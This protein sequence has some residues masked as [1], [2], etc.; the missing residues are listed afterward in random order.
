M[1]IGLTQRIFYHKQRAYDS[2]E[3][4]WYSF[5]KGHTLFPIAND[6]EQDFK[7]L[8]HSLD[9]LIITGGNDPTVR[10]ITETKL[11]SEMMLLKKPVVG[12]CHGAFL[13]TTLLGGEIDDCSYHMDTEHTVITDDGRHTVN[14]YHDYQITKL[15]TTATVL[16]RDTEGN[17]EAWIDGTLAGIVWHPERM[18]IP[19]MPK[20]VAL[21]LKL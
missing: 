8:A 6:I 21:L 4:G 17:C 3:H 16:A 1:N 19:F 18:T 13:L 12:I 10:R 2:L 7:A 15:H 9:I 5:L 14:S 20:E 11:A